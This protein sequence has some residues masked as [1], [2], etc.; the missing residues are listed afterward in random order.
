MKNNLV[1]GMISRPRETINKIKDMEYSDLRV[2]IYLIL[3]LQMIVVA[4]L[5]NMEDTSYVALLII[6]VLLAIP[7]GLLSTY[8]SS[9]ILNFIV[10]KIGKVES[11]SD[12]LYKVTFFTLI[13]MAL[14]APLA[15]CI[16]IANSTH[17]DILLG[18]YY[19]VSVWIYILF[20]LG[21]QNIYNLTLGKSILMI[22]LLFIVYILITLVITAILATFF[23][24]ALFLAQP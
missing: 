22:L 12:K 5:S 9:K 24:G 20:V 19:V 10:T 14:L 7:L 21:V 1:W 3:I 16:P 6:S 17:T 2:S 11:Q 18:L 8:I 15:M 13:P 23:L 4:F